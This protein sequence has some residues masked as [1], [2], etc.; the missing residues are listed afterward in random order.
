MNGIERRV[1]MRY[2]R[3]E[4]RNESV[5]QRKISILKRWTPVIAF[6]TFVTTWNPFIVFLVFIISKAAR[7]SLEDSIAINKSGIK[8][9]KLHNINNYFLISFSIISPKTPYP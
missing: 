1:K 2:S 8:K 5:N 4:Y 6:I 9:N 3:D 7:K